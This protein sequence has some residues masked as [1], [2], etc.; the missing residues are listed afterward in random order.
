VNDQWTLAAIL[1]VPLAT[2]M[3]W[4]RFSQPTTFEKAYLPVMA[5]L[6]LTQVAVQVWNVA[7]SAGFSAA[8]PY[9]PAAKISVAEAAKRAFEPSLVSI[10]A[11]GALMLW[12]IG[13]SFF[14]P[15][16]K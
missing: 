2:G 3:G 13:L 6:F 7:I 10:A 8:V 4:L 9:I 14:K 15:E 1:C 16:E 12:W 11:L 5:L